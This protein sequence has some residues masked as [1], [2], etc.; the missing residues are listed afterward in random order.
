VS[1]RPTRAELLFGHPAVADA[2]VVGVPDTRWGEA[3]KA[4]VVLKTGG[5]A[6]EVELIAYCRERIAHYKAP[7]SVDLV[8]SL[9]RNPSGK[10]LKRVLRAPYWRGMSA[11]STEGATRL[12]E[13]VSSGRHVASCGLRRGDLRLTVEPLRSLG[14]G[15]P[16]ARPGPPV[17]DH[18]AGEAAQCSATLSVAMNF[19]DTQAVS[20][21][22]RCRSSWSPCWPN[23]NC[24]LAAGSGP[25]VRVR[26]GP[27]AEG[28]RILSMAPSAGPG[29]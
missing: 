27:A 25:Q 11:R 21:G 24:R 17:P 28:S 15:R 2:A 22:F 8:E 6:S 10:V 29:Q 12:V 9:E 20:M 4:M 5:Q 26:R 23:A 19:G 14:V 7:K 18:Q 3:V 1:T 16:R 13:L